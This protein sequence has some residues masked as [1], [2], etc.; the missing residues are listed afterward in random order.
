MEEGLR[1]EDIREAFKTHE[2]DI[3]SYSPLALAFV[4]DAVYSLAVRT[5]ILEQGNTRVE[6]LHSRVSAYAR[7]SYQS[8]MAAAIADELSEDEADIYRRGRNAKSHAAP[9]SATSGDYHRATGLEALIGYLY[10]KGEENRILE[11]IRK[12][13]EI[14]KEKEDGIQ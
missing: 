9:K 14:L 2:Q 12:G 8:A 7:A 13:M 6:K 11:L 3:R 4:G 10:L 1:A 5:M